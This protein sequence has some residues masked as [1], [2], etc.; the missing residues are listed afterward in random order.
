MEKAIYFTRTGATFD[1]L[2]SKGLILSG[3]RK[4]QYHGPWRELFIPAHPTIW[5][6]W[7][8]AR[9]WE[10]LPMIGQPEVKK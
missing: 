10:T 4:S 7:E 9:P 6:P 3:D 5:F 1:V 8:A 2:C